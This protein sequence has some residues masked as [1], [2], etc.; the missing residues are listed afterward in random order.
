MGGGG[1]GDECKSECECGQ[2]SQCPLAYII[3]HSSFLLSPPPSHTPSLHPQESLSDCLLTELQNSSITTGFTSRYLKQ[4]AQGMHYV[5]SRGF[6]H[7]N[8]S[9]ASLFL[10]TYGTVKIADFSRARRDGSGVEDNVHDEELKSDCSVRWMA[11]EVI[12]GRRW[13]RASDVW[14]VVH[15]YAVT[16]C[17]LEFSMHNSNI[18]VQC[19]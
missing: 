10:D 13:S 12:T 2:Y 19:L 17:A 6:L 18:S 5:H 1:G 4:T 8:L 14:Y 15:I 7:C 9:A 3:L 16:V 11:P